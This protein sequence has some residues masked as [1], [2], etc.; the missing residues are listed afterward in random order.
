MK[1]VLFEMTL[2][3]MMRMIAG[4]RYYGDSVAEVVE[5]SKF[6]E[7][8]T[9]TFLLGS[10]TNIAD[11]LPVLRWLGVGG[12]EK[13]LI[14]LQ[15]KRDNFMQILI[16]ELRTMRCGGEEMKKKTMIE[17]LLDLQESEPEYYKDEIIRGLML[18]SY[19][20]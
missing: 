10:V 5:A 1:S 12:I 8:V 20:I 6:R 13:R 17:V 18:V 16:R 11:F 14:L 15:K 9:E 2:N 19:K 7:I 4:R 3:V